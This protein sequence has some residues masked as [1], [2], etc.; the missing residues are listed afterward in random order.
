MDR[1]IAASPGD[2]ALYIAR[3]ELLRE[4]GAWTPALAD[5]DRAEQLDPGLAP[6]HLHRAELLVALGSFADAREEVERFLER[7]P[8]ALDG[9]LTRARIRVASAAP[10]EAAADY[11]CVIDGIR[12]PALPNPEIYLERARALASAGELERALRGLGEGLG[13]LGPATALELETIALE[14]RRGATDDALARLDRLTERSPRKDLWLARRA[15][16]LEQAG[17]AEAAYHTYREALREI[18]RLPASRRATQQT[19]D[20]EATARLALER[21]DGELVH[22]GDSR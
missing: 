2:G 8:E 3:S 10:L 17:C 16:L 6:V 19:V 7:E 20:L 15:D 18:E 4:R 22:P 1:R 14:I 21:L 12:P 9:Y 5:L 13:R 11:D